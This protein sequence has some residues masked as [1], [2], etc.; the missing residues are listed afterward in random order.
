MFLSDFEPRSSGKSWI[1]WLAG[2]VG[3]LGISYW[4]NGWFDTGTIIFNLDAVAAL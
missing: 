2:D 3:F 4:P 1:E